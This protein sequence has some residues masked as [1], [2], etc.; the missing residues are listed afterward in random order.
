MPLCRGCACPLSLAQGHIFPNTDRTFT[1]DDVAALLLRLDLRE[2]QRSQGFDVA[3][4]GNASPAW[5]EPMH[6]DLAGLTEAGATW[7]MESLMHFDPLE[8]S[9]TVVDAGPPTP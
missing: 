3:V 5:E 4:A 7:W 8:L 9:L 1:P 2:D 6:V